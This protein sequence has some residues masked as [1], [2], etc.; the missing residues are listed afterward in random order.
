[1]AEYNVD[2]GLHI[3]CNYINN[4]E[5]KSLLRPHHMQN[6][7]AEL[8]CNNIGTEDSSCLSRSLNPLIH[9]LEE[10]KLLSEDKIIFLLIRHF[11]A[12]T[13][14]EATFSWTQ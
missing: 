9:T 2:S 5:K 11:F 3:Q 4:L 14:Q 10:K 6:D 12:L 1:M 8:Y 13:Q 7:C